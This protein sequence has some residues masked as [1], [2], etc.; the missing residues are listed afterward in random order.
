ME[1][2]MIAHDV[3]KWYIDSCKKIAY[4]FPKAHAVAYVIMALRIAWFKIYYPLEYYATYFSLRCDAY[5]IK[6]MIEGKEAIRDRLTRIKNMIKEKDRA[7]TT[8]DESLEEV[9]EVALEMTTRGY[10]FANL[11]LTHSQAK[12]FI[13]DKEHDALIPPLM[14]LDGLGMAAAESFVVAREKSPFIS[15]EDMMKR[16]QINSTQLKMLEQLKVLD[17]LEEENQMQFKLF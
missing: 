7:L 15:K 13:V 1:D 14:V 6:T 16:T 4:M 5:D 3:P 10:S 9:L 12:N 8:K 11:S 17:E 2:D